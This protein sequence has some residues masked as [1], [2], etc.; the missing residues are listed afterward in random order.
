[1]KIT[2]LKLGRKNFDKT[3][4]CKIQFFFSS[5]NEGPKEDMD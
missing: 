5:K 2:R 1:M 3:A 4:E